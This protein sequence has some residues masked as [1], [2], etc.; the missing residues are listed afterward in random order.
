MWE[1][2]LSEKKTKRTPTARLRQLKDLLA[3]ETE[4][5]GSAI[6]ALETAI[7]CNWNGLFKQE[8]HEQPLKP[9]QRNLQ[10]SQLQHVSEPHPDR[11]KWLEENRP[12]PVKWEKCVPEVFD[13]EFPDR[14][15][16]VPLFE[17]QWK[18]SPHRPTVLRTVAQGEA[19]NS[20]TDWEKLVHDAFDSGFPG[21]SVG[22]R[23]F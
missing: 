20:S 21:S 9:H 22:H 6:L 15:S 4:R 18:G 1:R 17:E 19:S 13:P 7:R 2:H 5:A 11:V 14:R 10:G 8:K 23:G 12:K 3:W 16:P